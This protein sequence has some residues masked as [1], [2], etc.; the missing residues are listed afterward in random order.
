MAWQGLARHR[1]YHGQITAAEINERQ[2]DN[3]TARRGE[4]QGGRRR[5]EESERGRETTVRGA[6]VGASVFIPSTKLAGH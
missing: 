2:S 3:R 4:G 1:L 5:R 6:A